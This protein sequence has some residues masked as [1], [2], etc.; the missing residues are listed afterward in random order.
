MATKK[1][2]VRKAVDDVLSKTDIDERI[3]AW[4]ANRKNNFSIAVDEMP[5]VCLALVLVGS[6]FGFILGKLF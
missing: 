1:D 6:F 4:A 3:A 5:Y 2:I